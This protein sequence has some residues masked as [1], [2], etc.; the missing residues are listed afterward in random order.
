MRHI[1]RLGDGDS[2]LGQPEALCGTW[3]CGVP[4]NDTSKGR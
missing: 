3:V 4:G 1:I 2:G